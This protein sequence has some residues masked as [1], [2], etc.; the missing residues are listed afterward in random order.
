VVASVGCIV[1]NCTGLVELQATHG[2]DMPCHL[3]A[4]FGDCAHALHV[5]TTVHCFD[6][7]A[8]LSS[9]TTPRGRVPRSL[10]DF[11]VVGVGVCIHSKTPKARPVWARTSCVTSTLAF[12]I[13][14]KPL[15]AR[16]C[17]IWPQHAQLH[18]VGTPAPLHGHAAMS[19]Q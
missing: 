9:L 4:C 19:A 11:Y 16:L 1:A 6:G 18:F 5:C 17:P 7:G 10:E 15:R 13:S 8:C 2:G 14:R 3:H 12:R